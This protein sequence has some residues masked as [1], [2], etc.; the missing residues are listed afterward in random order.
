MEIDENEDPEDR[1]ERDQR[2]RSNRRMS[3]IA[4]VTAHVSFF[5]LVAAVLL[6]M[7][8]SILSGF[9][10]G[11]TVPGYILV[12]SVISLV[13]IAPLASM[14]TLLLVIRLAWKGERNLE[15]PLV[16]GVPGAI[17]ALIIVTF[18]LTVVV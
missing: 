9:P 13:V 11:P 18:V 10:I 17:V 7:A 5:A 8:G 4:V 6:F 14:V 3:K 2:E 16:F 1:L 15:T 12:T